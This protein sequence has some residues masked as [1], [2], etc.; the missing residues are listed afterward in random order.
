MGVADPDRIAVMGWSAGGHLVNKLITFTNRF[1]AAA[2]GAGVANWISLYGT[3]DNRYDRDIWFGGSL[4][5][6]NAPVQTYWEHSPL[7]YIASAR[8]PT[9]FL[10]GEND[11]RVPAAQS[12][13]IVR[14][15]KAQGVPSELHIAPGEGHIWLSPSHQLHKMNAE[16][17]WFENTFVNSP[18]H[19]SR[20]PQRATIPSSPIPRLL[21]PKRDRLSPFSLH[22]N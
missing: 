4:W 7:K 5:Q 8:T 20:R 21:D 14:A 11:P 18:T 16:L 22:Q 2:S 17:E 3:S 9:L 15:L 13:E 10:T 12:I 1:K 6:K 19:R